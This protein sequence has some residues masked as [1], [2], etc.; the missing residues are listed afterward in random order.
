MTHSRYKALVSKA[1]LL[2]QF[3]RRDMTALNG[4]NALDSVLITQALKLLMALVRIPS[5]MEVMDPDFCSFV[6]DRSTEMR[7]T[8]K[9]R[10]LSS[11]L[12]SVFSRTEFQYENND[13]C[14]CGK[15]CGRVHDIADRVKGNGVY[16]YRLLVYRK[17]IGQALM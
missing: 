8:R 2:S 13:C 9:R 15:N 5:V 6:I 14:T 11:T 7:K 12:T 3:I 17:L 4:S 1:G 10:N 16:A